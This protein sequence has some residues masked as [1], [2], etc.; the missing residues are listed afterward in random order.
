MQRNSLTKGTDLM[1]LYLMRH[2]E[3]TLPNIN[4]ERPLSEIGLVEAKKIRDFLERSQV[5]IDQIYHSGI[6][7]AEQTAKILAECIEPMPKLDL[8]LGLM[9]EDDIKPI[10]LY[11]NHWQKHT[12]I[13]GHMPFLGKLFSMLLLEKEETERIFFHTAAIACLEKIASFH[14]SLSWFTYPDLL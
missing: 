4:P 9:P 7:R 14:W 3:A 12:L 8:L 13:V 10:A 6:L 1:K 2:G 11:C 5:Q